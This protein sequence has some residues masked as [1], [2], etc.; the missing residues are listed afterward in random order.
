MQF[1]GWRRLKFQILYPRKELLKRLQ[2]QDL[3]SPGKAFQG[4]GTARK[5]VRLKSSE[6]GR[7]GGHVVGEESWGRPGKSYRAWAVYTDG[8]L[9]VLIKIWHAMLRSLGFSSTQEKVTEGS[10]ASTTFYEL[11][12]RGETDQ[13]LEDQLRSCSR[14]PRGKGMIRNWV[15][16]WQNINSHLNY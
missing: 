2:S 14:D 9:W 10:L 15:R 1:S 4:A 5:P 6:W 7:G 3:T 8:P 16:W 13:R 11:G 12:G